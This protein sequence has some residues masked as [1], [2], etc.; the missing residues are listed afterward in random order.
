LAEPARRIVS[1]NPTTT[2][3][4]FAIGAG[5]RVVGRTRWCDWPPAA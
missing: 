2:E 4:L 3:L 1:L 5:D